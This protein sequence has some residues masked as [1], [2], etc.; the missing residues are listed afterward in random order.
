MNEY[1]LYVAANKDSLAFDSKT[2]TSITTLFA[3]AKNEYREWRDLCIWIEDIF[4]QR[5]QI[6]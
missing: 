5:T 6:N 4:G 3:W 1:T 2:G